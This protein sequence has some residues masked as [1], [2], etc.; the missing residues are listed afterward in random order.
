MPCVPTEGPGK[1]GECKFPFRFMNKDYT[2]CTQDGTTASFL[3]N[4][5]WCA[6]AVDESNNMLQEHWGICGDDCARYGIQNVSNFLYLCLLFFLFHI[7][8]VFSTL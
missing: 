5:F 1:G 8:I 7:T 2:K 4:K 3:T 6:T